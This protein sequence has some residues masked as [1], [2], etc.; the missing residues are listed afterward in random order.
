MRKKGKI[1]INI[2]LLV[3]ILCVIIIFITL[4]LDNFINIANKDITMNEDLDDYQRRNMNLNFSKPLPNS[5]IPT[6]KV[7]KT[8][9]MHMSER[10]VNID[11]INNNFCIYIKDIEKCY[12]LSRYN[13]FFSNSAFLKNEDYYVVMDYSYKPITTFIINDHKEQRPK[14]LVLDKQKKMREGKK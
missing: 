10:I 8:S 7:N 2:F 9:K 6:I 14:I 1:Q 5:S 12:N 11:K 4:F 13:Q 3:A